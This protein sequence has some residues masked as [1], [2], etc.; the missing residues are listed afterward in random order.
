MA[1]ILGLTIVSRSLLLPSRHLRSPRIVNRA[2]DDR[3]KR[4]IPRDVKEGVLGRR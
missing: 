3:K 4:L 1:S 2:S